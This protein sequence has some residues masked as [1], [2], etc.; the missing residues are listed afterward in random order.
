MIPR[1]IGQELSQRFG[2]ETWIELDREGGSERVRWE[3]DGKRELL[4]VLVRI[5][6]GEGNG[7]VSVFFPAW[8]H[9]YFGRRVYLYCFGFVYVFVSGSTA[10]KTAHLLNNQA[11]NLNVV[12]VSFPLFFSSF[13][14]S[15]PI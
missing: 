1:S 9:M 6:M 14:Q 8:A 5:Y 11:M 13:Q 4:M 12:D 7:F 3:E 15:V 10:A 2:L